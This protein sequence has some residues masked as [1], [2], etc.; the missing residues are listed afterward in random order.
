[1]SVARIAQDLNDLARS[2]A[3][4]DRER[5]LMAIVDLCGGAE[6]AVHAPPVQDLLSSIFLDLVAGAE[7]E[8]RSHLSVK[9]AQAEWPPVSLVN[10]L[11]LDDIEIARP[12][13]ASSPV[14]RDV[15]LVRLLIEATIEHQIEVASRPSIGAP[16]IETI[17]SQGAAPV[18]TALASNDTAEISP[19]A[20]KRLVE[21]SQ[22]ISAMRSPLA[23]HP[24]LTGDM[25]ER[26]YQWVGQSLR[27]AIVSRFRVDVAALDRAIA[28]AVDEAHARPASPQGLAR[29]TNAAQAAVEARLII[30]LQA[31]GQLRPSY[32][33][34]ALRE[35]KLALFETALC[36]LG[37]FKPEEV[38]QA[39]TCD[40]PEV[41]ALACAAV[42]VDK[43]A[44][45][46]IVELV[47]R[48][49]SGRP[50]G[51][52]ARARKAFQ[53]FGQDRAGEAALAFR[54]AVELV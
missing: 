36:A 29:P 17:I 5:L 16:V 48:S 45:A 13:I 40:R 32:L 46:S 34:R 11:A 31:A 24:R 41:L 18:M 42:G 54:K 21:A 12:I 8:I 3:P 7:H 51:D 20:M 4:A 47:R 1:V 53:T 28:E 9:L 35:G 22:S 52:L 43:G 27:S 49:N 30:K 6:D 37:D 23:R 10:V 38:R 33:L 44:F 39:L 26:L 50:A 25:A 19:T 2:R 14:L 15:D